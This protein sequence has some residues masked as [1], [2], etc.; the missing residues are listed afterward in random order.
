MRYKGRPGPT[1]RTVRRSE[2]KP[3]DHPLPPGDFANRKLP[4]AKRS[5][6]W[7]HSH[8]GDQQPLFFGRSGDN[9]FDSPTKGFGVLYVG[10]DEY[11]A[12][13]ETLGRLPDKGPVPWPRVLTVDA[14]EKRRLAEVIVKGPL[15]LVDL[16]GPGLAS[17]GADARLFA[18]AYAIAQQWSAAIHDHPRKPDGLLYLS[19]HDPSRECAAVFDRAAPRLK[20]CDL[21]SWAS[22][23]IRL[24]EILEK[25]GIGLL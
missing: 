13:I 17:L 10:R 4:L 20:A 3:G 23:R 14:C 6:H 9:R 1:E 25:F 16:T 11:C 21:G 19:R 2:D 22:D 12:F 5:R 15:V 7:F 18:G 24:A 8:W